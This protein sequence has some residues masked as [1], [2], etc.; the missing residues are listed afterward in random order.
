MKFEM[1][2]TMVITMGT[3]LPVATANFDIYAA[4]VNGNGIGG[5]AWGF[6]VYD[7]PPG[8][9][10]VHDWIWAKRDDVSSARGIRCKGECGSST[11]GMVPSNVDELEMNFG[12]YH[13]TIYK[14]R[15]FG[16]YNREGHKVGNCMPYEGHDF[17]CGGVFG[18]TNGHRKFRCLVN[19][20]NADD[21][22]DNRPS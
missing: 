5:D 7:T 22:N 16:F 18:R 2:S 11:S 13:W 17:T 4:G 12:D 19:S 9:S 1:L 6:Q 10:D 14:N 20:V 15:G 3:L 21:I 8:C